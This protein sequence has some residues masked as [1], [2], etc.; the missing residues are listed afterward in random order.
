MAAVYLLGPTAAG[1]SALALAIASRLACEIIS[2]DSGQVYRG[3]DIGTAKPD[4]AA[5]RAVVHHLLDIRNPDQPYSAGE[6]RRDALALIAAVEA[7]GHVPLL[8]GGTFLYFRALERGLAT[9]PAADIAA[10]RAIEAD[11]AQVGWPALHAEL[12]QIDPLLAARIAPTDRQRISRGLEVFRLSGQA[13]S[14]WHAQTVPSARGSSALRLIL[15]PA[16]RQTLYAAVDARFDAMLAA[17]LVDEVARLRQADYSGALP[18]LRAIGYRQAWSYLAGEL[19]Y[20]TLVAAG[21]A[22]SRQYAKRQLTWLRGD[23]HGHWLDPA[24]GSV[25]AR[26]CD[27]IKRTRDL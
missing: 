19:D 21:K 13:L 12:A 9:L 20:P 1:K 2:V 25:T 18:A 23:P 5:R 11:A 8:V 26:V 15:A 10:R 24:G 3:L 4:A 17:G 14:T 7:R 16:S 22:A 6:F 27:L